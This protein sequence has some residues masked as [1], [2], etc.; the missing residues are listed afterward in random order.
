LL[1]Q[2]LLEF[3]NGCWRLGDIAA[4]AVKSLDKNPI[5][6]IAKNAVMYVK[7][8]VQWTEKRLG[9]LEESD[10]KSMKPVK[11]RYLLP[12]EMRGDV[13]KRGKV[14]ESSLDF[15]EIQVREDLMRSAI[16]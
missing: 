10:E 4:G 5:L 2:I 8:G 6:L 14:R 11:L 9:D 12:R 13:N 16:E 15:R 1:T 7:S 3:P